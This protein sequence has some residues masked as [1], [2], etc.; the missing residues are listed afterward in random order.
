MLMSP[1]AQGVD[2]AGNPIQGLALSNAHL[3]TGPEAD[4]PFLAFLVAAHVPHSQDLPRSPTPAKWSTLLEDIK[5]ART[6]YKKEQIRA[7]AE[8]E[9]ENRKKD[10]PDDSGEGR[11]LGGPS[12][13]GGN[14][15]GSSGSRAPDGGNK[16]AGPEGGAVETQVGSR[17]LVRR[18]HYKWPILSFP[19]IAPAF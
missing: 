13:G 6:N 12:A 9:A 1:E 18:T 5:R 19:S 17:Y 15:D 8:R 16:E 3:I 10:E 4:M 11:S 2:E 7:V 14:P